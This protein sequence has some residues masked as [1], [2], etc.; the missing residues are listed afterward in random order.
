[1]MSAYENLI[2]KYESYK[3]MIKE[4]QL[5]RGYKGLY[6]NNKILIEK[7]LT[8][9]EKHC[10]LA[11]EIG[12]Y[13]TSVGNIINLNEINNR[14]QEKVARKWAYTNVI[15]LSEIVTAKN[16]DCQCNYEIADYLNVTEEFLNDAIEYYFQKYGKQTK[17]QN[18][19]ITF[20]PLNVIKI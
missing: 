20:E 19:V 15:P 17:W 13:F 18:Y 11:E 5:M 14:K 9:T 7:S 3:I 10:V 6:K 2:C 12:H 4:V 1:M 8:E 16:K